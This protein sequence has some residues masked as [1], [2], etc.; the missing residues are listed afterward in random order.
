[1]DNAD[2][3]KVV[4]IGGGAAG[5]TAAVYAARADLRPVVFAGYQSGG[6]LM[7]TTEVEN[8]PGFPDPIMGPDLMA[9]MRRQSERFGA[10]ILDVD[11][12]S[13][14]FRSTPLCVRAE[15]QDYRTHTV[16]IATG[17]NAR[18]LGL[19]SEERL[20]GRGVSSC[21]T[22]DGAFFR[23]QAVAVIGG[24]DSAME[25]ALY[26]AR[27]ASK[28]TVIHRR[29]ELRA[30]KIMQARA[31]EHPKVD[32]IWN[33][34]VDEVIGDKVVSAL[35]LRNVNTGEVTE[36]PFSAMFVAIGHTPNTQLFAGQI[37]LDEMGYVV[38]RDRTR[39]SRPNVFVA[40]DV[41]DTRYRQAITAAGAGCMAAID[42]ARFLEEEGI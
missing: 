14:D 1:M 34:V 24:G 29:N 40:G 21:A 2:I 17:A 36:R 16:I 10:R 30:S 37:D 38:A 31:I 32:F 3:E 41:Q 26:L 35:K 15:D 23:D 28:V 19:P 18:W 5:L 7:L 42:V 33:S 12:E 8:F 25:E 39:T 20:I 11:V 9:G 13:V 27:I 6:Q 22:C 4:I